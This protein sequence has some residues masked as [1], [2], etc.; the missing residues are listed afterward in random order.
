MDMEKGEFKQVAKWEYDVRKFK[1]VDEILD[2]AISREIDAQ[3]FYMEL[4]NMVESPKQAKVLSDLAAEEVEHKKTLE[5]V[6]AGKKEIGDREVGTL[7]IVDYVKD[8]IPHSKMN[9][10][11]LLVV[12][13][14]K[15]ETSRKLYADLAA[16]AQE[17][18][19][20]DIFLK[21]AQEEAKHKLRFELDYDLLKFGT[22]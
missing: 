10:I 3:A 21:L 14:K 7:E 22:A 5:A 8:I 17:Q 20:K 4:A 15:E 12:G 16:T 13:M 9:Y 19:L 6:K 2:F 18:G 1:S 11:D